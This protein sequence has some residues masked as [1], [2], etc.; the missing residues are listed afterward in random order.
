[1]AVC[2]FYK[3]HSP[4][5]FCHSYTHSAHVKTEAQPF[6]TSGLGV[7]QLLRVESSLTPLSSD[8]KNILCH[9]AWQLLENS[10]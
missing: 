1:M 7:T 10:R 8:A 3:M 4:T 9:L 2:T 5:L 6:E